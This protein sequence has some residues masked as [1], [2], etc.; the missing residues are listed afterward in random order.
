MAKKRGKTSHSTQTRTK[1]LESTIVE[2]LVAL[3]KINADL[4]EKFDKLSKEL[5]NLLA[6]FETAARSFAKNPALEGLDKD[7]EFLEKIDKLLEQN[8]TIAKG[9][10]LMEEKVRERM[11]QKPTS[12]ES[13]ENTYQPSPSSSSRPLPRF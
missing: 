9:L 1:S 7:K 13:P 2:N 8:K 5:S 11:Y 12:E 6:L 10:A 3:Q 4:A